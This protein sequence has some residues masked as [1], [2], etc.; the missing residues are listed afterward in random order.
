MLSFKVA[1]DRQA[2]DLDRLFIPSGPPG[3]H[4]YHHYHLP[5][6]PSA[7]EEAL[8]A[9]IVDYE[10][11]LVYLDI[12]LA[13]TVRC[14]HSGA[15]LPV[16]DWVKLVRAAESSSEGLASAARDSILYLQRT[17]LY[18]RNKVLVHPKTMLPFVKTDNV[19]NLLFYRLAVTEH[20]QEQLNQLNNLLH[21]VRPDMSDEMKVGREIDPHLALNW[22]GARSNL[23][24]DWQQLNSLREC[25]GFMLPG[26]Y[27]IAPAVDQFV[28]RCIH[29]VPSSELASIA[30]A[31]APTGERPVGRGASVAAAVTP[32]DRQQ[33]DRL[34]REGVEIGNGGDH[35]GAAKVFAEI[36]SRD[37]EDGEA[38][39]N[40]GRALVSIN[41][42][43]V[44][45]EHL[46]SALALSATMDEVR[47]DLVKGTSTSVL[48]TMP[49]GNSRRRPLTIVA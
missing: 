25:F 22:I 42:L 13:E 43:D 44:G 49:P 47:S 24:A 1:W 3:T 23:V 7:R 38:H 28:D 2:A 45:L 31:P 27:E 48:V 36:V 40:L 34:R 12:A 18:V 6:D 32:V 11:A 39:L 30:L 5:S 35:S 9:A 20:S 8:A 15:A 10:T 21:E 19:G 17:P 4:A 37:P 16:S 29:Q 41:D 26:A 33:L 46:Y 14:L